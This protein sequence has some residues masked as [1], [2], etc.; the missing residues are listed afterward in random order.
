MQ[1]RRERGGGNHR[2]HGEQGLQE[3]LLTLGVGEED[4]RLPRDQQ[5]TAG[6]ALNDAKCDQ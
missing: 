5:G 4:E 1:G 6:K 2:A 3:W